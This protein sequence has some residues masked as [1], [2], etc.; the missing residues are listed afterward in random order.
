M[1]PKTLDD[2]RQLGRLEVLA[3]THD[4]GW[5]FYPHNPITFTVP[6]T[7][8]KVDCDYQDP[9][10]RYHVAMPGTEA[11]IEI[12]GTLWINRGQK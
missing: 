4:E 3:G 7:L 6:A 10:G 2:F 9:N 11:H 5:K 1:Q 8:K 12:S